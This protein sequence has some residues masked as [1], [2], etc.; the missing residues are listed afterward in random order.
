MSG[1]RIKEQ[2]RALLEAIE[3]MDKG[4][5]TETVVPDTIDGMASA[6]AQEIVEFIPKIVQQREHIAWLI[7]EIKKLP[8]VMTPVEAEWQP[9][10]EI[11]D[12]IRAEI[13]QER[14][15]GPP[16]PGPHAPTGGINS[17]FLRLRE[18]PL[19]YVPPRLL[20]MPTPEFIDGRRG[21]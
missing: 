4:E 5:D 17:R 21:A 20:R 14:A 2:Q 18:Y 3:S 8:G 15:M 9:S 13:D 1:N 10:Q 16:I 7:E 6:L 12:S 19:P 11:A